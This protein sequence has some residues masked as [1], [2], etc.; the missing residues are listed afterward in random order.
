MNTVADHTVLPKA[1]TAEDVRIHGEFVEPA[2]ARASVIFV[3]GSGSARHSPHDQALARFLNRH[4]YA[5]LLLDILATEEEQADIQSGAYRFN[6][7]L[8]AHRLLV[9]SDKLANFYEPELPYAYVG[10]GTGAAAALVA[11][12]RRPERVAA[13]IC[14]NGCPDLAGKD[15]AY[16]R[17]PTLLIAGGEDA[18]GLASNQR[19]YAQLQGPRDLLVI[20]GAGHL[21]DDPSS[22][23]ELEQAILRWL[24]M[25]VAAYARH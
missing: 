10:V 14:R 4:G 13:V 16:V 18:E 2:T 23:R 8:L 25:H 20:P 5:T 3:H 15:L 12:S 11:A 22:I 21:L 7:E 1:I 24:D 6:I 9:A 19:A 17:A